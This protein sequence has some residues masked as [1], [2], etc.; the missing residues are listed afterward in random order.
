MKNSLFE[1]GNDNESSSKGKDEQTLEMK[2]SR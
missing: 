2:V 1:K